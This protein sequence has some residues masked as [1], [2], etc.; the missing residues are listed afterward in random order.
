MASV[1]PN[2]KRNF[3]LVCVIAL[4]MFLRLYALERVPQEFDLDEANL[5]YDSY[6]LLYYGVEGNGFSYPIHLVG[7]G[8]GMNALPAYI[9]MPFI[10]A[11]GLTIFA[12]R[13]PG[14][15][16]GI[17]SVIFFYLAINKIYPKVAVFS[18]F[19]LAISPWYIMHTRGSNE[20]HMYPGFFLLGFAFFIFAL[21]NRKHLYP[22]F[23][24]FGL[25]LY[26]FWSGYV[27]VPAFLFFGLF[28][29]LRKNIFTFKSLILPSLM[30]FLMAL[31]LMVFLVINY[32]H[33]PSLHIG[34]ITVPLLPG[35]SHIANRSALSQSNAFASFFTSL[36]AFLK[37]FYARSGE[38]GFSFAFLLLCIGLCVTI[39]ECR[40]NDG[41]HAKFFM[42]LWFAVTLFSA[43]LTTLNFTRMNSFFLPCLYFIAVAV[44]FLSA[45]ASSLAGFSRNYLLLPFIGMYLFQSGGFIHSQFW[46]FIKAPS[47][48]S[49]YVY[50][51]QA[52][53]EYAWQGTDSDICV[54]T[55]GDKRTYYTLIMF[56]SKVSPVVFRDTVEYRNPDGE[57]RYANTFDRYYFNLEKC[58]GRDIGAYILYTKRDE[59]FID[60]HSFKSTKEF[61]QY[62]VGIK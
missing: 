18:A 12:A 60:S 49:S 5:A 46:K 25:S 55:T 1:S 27:L 3:L 56:F 9:Q 31:P 26:T 53:L 11:F 10:Y 36:F 42:L 45:K 57:F 62:T 61:G 54:S 17:L 40:K 33:F 34:P 39:A 23:L 37:T 59:E 47:S 8:S 48:S 58:E 7:T 35:P 4:S 32:F 24:F 2:A 20:S 51:L 38:F 15:I 29:A 16:L 50:P 22:S 30:L 44:Q 43:G 41:A 14:A 28:Y 13:L 21:E 52:A 19:L 6:S